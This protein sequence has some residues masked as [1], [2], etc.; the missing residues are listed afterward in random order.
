MIWNILVKCIE[1]FTNW[2]EESE[3]E[4]EEGSGNFLEKVVTIIKELPGKLWEWL[5]DTITKVGEFFGNII[6]TGKTKAGEFLGKVVDTIKELPGKIWKWLCDTV[7]KVVK[8]GGDMVEKAKKAAQDTFDKIVNKIK[9]IPGKMLEIGKNIVEGIWDGI[10]NATKWITDKVK[11]FAKKI[12]DGIKSALGIKS[13][14]KVFR[15][16]V[17]KNLALGIGE[18]FTEE[19]KNVSEQMEKTIPTDFDTDLNTA[20]NLAT[21]DT[22]LPI[23]INRKSVEE[24][25]LKNESK[26]K[27]NEELLTQILNTA[28]GI[29]ESLYGK[30]VSALVDGVSVSVNDREIARLVRRYA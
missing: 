9:E 15:E 20:V 26:D 28:R 14:S 11:E 27:K 2:G 12:L 23:E 7:Q 30:F 21:S 5:K 18:G 3:E 10:K 17:G 25:R 4:G 19:M 6:E 8:W 1:K 24:L 29:N 13:P 22:S 16:Q